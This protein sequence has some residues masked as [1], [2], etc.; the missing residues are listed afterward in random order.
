MQKEN[1]YWLT[2]QARQKNPAFMRKKD[3]LLEITFH[4]PDKRRRDRDNNLASIKSA[5]D[6][7]ALAL[8]IDDSNF[9]YGA[10]KKGE[11]IKGGKIVVRIA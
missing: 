4:P 3:Y 7:I 6:G 5:I 10:V 9:D 1:A 11:P 8:E 2:M